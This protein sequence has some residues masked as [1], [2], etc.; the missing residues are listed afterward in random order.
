MKIE[1]HEDYLFD[2]VIKN[3]RENKDILISGN[4]VKNTAVVIG[5]VTSSTTDVNVESCLRDSIPIY[6]RKGGGGAVV[7][8]PGVAVISCTLNKKGN[9][10]DL[11]EFLNICVEKIKE[12]LEKA[13]DTPFSI[14][15]SGDLC[16]GDKKV[17]GSSIYSS[18]EYITYYCTLIVKGN[19]EAISKYLL[20]PSKEPTYRKGRDHKN[21]ITS[22]A[23][24]EIGIDEKSLLKSIT[25]SLEEIKL[26]NI[27]M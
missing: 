10:V 6:R 11:L 24:H 21:F 3:S 8:F 7:L 25:S 17:L 16:I 27:I 5:R 20:Y 4:F 26:K 14:R 2:K 12:G 15:G 18:K 23:K 22:I 13:L 9:V 19:L 1:V